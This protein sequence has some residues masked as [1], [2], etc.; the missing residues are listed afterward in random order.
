MTATNPA[1]RSSDGVIEL[2]QYT[3]KPGK[4]DTLI[5]LFERKLVEAQEDAG[6]KILGQ[7]RDLD[8]PDRLVWLRSFADMEARKRA[9]AAF[10]GGPVWKA[11][12]EAANATMAD[13]DN[14]LLLR[15]VRPHAGFP[16]AQRPRPGVG[17]KEHPS[18]LI[19]TTLCYLPAPVDEQFIRFVEEDVLPVV[20]DAGARTIAVLQTEAAEN[21]FPLLPVR[22]GEHV[23]AWFCAFEN[24]AQHKHYADRLTAISHWQNRVLPQ[25][26]THL[27]AGPEQLRLAPT[28]SSAL[29]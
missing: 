3:L 21:T 6:M 15:P 25:L 19:T 8:N 2:R 9:L 18:S 26:M 29:R 22:E 12:R 10:Y 4:R 5:D 24:R 28:A 13:S 16:V 27:T 14:V 23:L 11:N 17:A 1:Q 20:G 7:F